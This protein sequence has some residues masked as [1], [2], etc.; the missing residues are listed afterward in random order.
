MNSGPF[1]SVSV[2]DIEFAKDYQYFVTIQFM[3]EKVNNV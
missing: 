2:Q 3:N 1:L